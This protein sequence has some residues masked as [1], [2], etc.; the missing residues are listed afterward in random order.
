M[1]IQKFCKGCGILLA[2]GFFGLSKQYFTFEDGEYCA[3]CAKVKVE[4]ARK[5]V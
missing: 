5:A 2:E 1:R 3:K 4:K